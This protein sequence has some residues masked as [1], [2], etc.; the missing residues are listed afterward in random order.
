[1]SFLQSVWR[2]KLHH[3]EPTLI[4]VNG[5]QILI[6]FRC[7][8]FLHS[9]CFHKFSLLFLLFFNFTF[10]TL[11]MFIEQCFCLCFFNP[12]SDVANRANNDVDW[13]MITTTWAFVII[14]SSM[15]PTV[16]LAAWLAFE[17]KVVLLIATW[18]L[19]MLS[20]FGK[21]HLVTIS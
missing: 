5:S 8:A 15:V 17:W 21:F 19:A 1:M 3:A 9:C 12:Y 4:S 16:N 2:A 7:L 18:E 6:T 13:I 20:N 10:T 11:L 14:W